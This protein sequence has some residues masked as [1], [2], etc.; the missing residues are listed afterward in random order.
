MATGSSQ[1]VKKPPPQRYHPIPAVILNCAGGYASI[2]TRI[3]WQ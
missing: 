3:R 1:D 2:A